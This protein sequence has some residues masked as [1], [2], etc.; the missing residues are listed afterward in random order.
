MRKLPLLPVF[1]AFVGLFLFAAPAA[2][3][4]AQG[5]AALKEG[6]A[7]YNQENYEEAITVL[8]RARAENPSSA[9]AAFYLGMAYRQTNDIQNAYKQF[10]DAVNLKPLSDNAVLELIE[11][12]TLLDR[13]DTARKW[14]GVA[15]EH[16]VYPA[17]V[18][19][20]K[21]TTLSKEVKYD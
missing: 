11:A 3:A 20:L 7:Q 15:E 14:I 18:A 10:E 2:P 9:E 17:R 16:K 21:G 5:S 13:L 19:F 1:V 6:V 8:T 4:F 12:S